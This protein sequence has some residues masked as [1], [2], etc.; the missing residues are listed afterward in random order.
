MNIL[1]LFGG[2]FLEGVNQTFGL[3]AQ[4]AEPPPRPAAGPAQINLRWY[5]IRPG[6]VAD[7]SR[8]CP[9]AMW[10]DEFLAALLENGRE[11]MIPQAAIQVAE[12]QR[13]N[14]GC[15]IFAGPQD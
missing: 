11:G 14:P 4:E 5:A 13:D 2:A 9:R 15:F 1:E 3:F 7:F 10:A 8:R 12:M 6:S